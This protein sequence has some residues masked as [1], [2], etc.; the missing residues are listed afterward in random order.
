M[1]L[2]E[3]DREALR[4]LSRAVEN[5]RQE[6]GRQSFVAQNHRKRDTANLRPVNA[7]WFFLTQIGIISCVLRVRGI[8]TAKVSA[9]QEEADYA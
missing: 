7:W 9:R 1:A 6:D 4:P 8:G 3:E 5:F 2:P